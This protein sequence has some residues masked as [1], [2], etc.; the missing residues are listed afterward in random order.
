MKKC[1]I[2]Q[3]SPQKSCFKSFHEL[4]ALRVNEILLISSP[5]DAFVMQED[6]HL[7]ER[8]IHEYQGL[9]LSRPPR[10]SWVSN[11]AEALKDLAAVSYDIVIV[12]PHI[13]DMD[14]YAL[15]GKIKS[16]YPDLPVYYFAYDAGKV[17]K[18]KQCYNRKIIDRTFIWRGNTDLLLALVKNREDSMNVDTDT[19]LADVRV[20]IFVE[21]SPF[22]LSTLLPYLYKE[23][24]MQTQAVMD[25]S[26]NE[27]ERILRMRTRPKILVAENYEQAWALYEKYKE[28]LM[29]VV[30]DVRY[31]KQGK[32]DAEAGIK[33][34]LTINREVPD[35][36]L[37]MLSSEPE[38]R[39]R[40]DAIPAFFLDKNS[41]SL[42]ADIRYFFVHYL[43]FGDFL[44]RMP[45]GRVVARASN[46]RSLA[47]ILHS[48][49]DESIAYHASHNHFSRWLMA[50]FEMQL[51]AGIRPIKVSDFP[52]T[53]HLKEMLT[54]VIRDRLKIK[55]KG[56]I[57]DFVS[58]EYDPDIDFVKIGK[59]SLG[60]KARGLAFI[61][62]MFR[63]NSEFKNLF[64]E[65]NIVLPRIV[66]ITTDGFDAFELE[67]DL[68]KFRNKVHTDGEI[69]DYFKKAGFP[70]W[71]AN[72]LRIFLRHT[73]GPLAVRSS[74][75]LEDAHYRP[76]AGAYATYMLPNNHPKIQVR[77]D[78]LIQA[79]KLVYASL[80]KEAPRVLAR[81][82][83][84]RPE[85]DKMAV[86][87]Q[88]LV[89]C[90]H[91]DFFYPGI[92]GVAQSYNFYP[93]DYMKPEEGVAHMAL[94]LGKI[95]M[96]GGVAIRF[97]PRY[98]QF[99]P[100]FSTVENILKN[101]QRYFYALRMKTENE[102]YITHPDM[103]LEKIN[104]DDAMDHAPVQRFSSTYVPEDGRIR[105]VFTQK[106]YPV[107]TF[108]SIL[109]FKEFPLGKILSQLLEVGRKGMGCPVEMEF[110]VNFNDRKTA[111]FYLLQ[112]RP[113]MVARDKLN[114]EINQNDLN[115]SFC[116]SEQAMG[117]SQETSIHDII[118]VKL[119]D[120]DTTGTVE[121]AEEI[122]QMNEL[123]KHNDR[124]YLLIGP[125]RWGTADPWLGIPVKWSHITGVGTIIET[126]SEKLSAD[127][128]QGSHFF[129]NITSLGINYLGVSQKD[130]NVIDW[131]WLDSQRV[132]KETRYLKYISLKKPAL[133]KINGKDST[134]VIRKPS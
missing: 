54:D 132:E 88:K 90:Q 57:S 78:Q 134:A 55:Q 17:L 76:S 6:G 62:S 59:G 96:D 115:R 4:I 116:Y 84:Y 97:S 2:H 20:V 118:Y 39:E 67:N 48:V 65:A 14:S 103:E 94:G 108:A 119:H 21:D 121:I 43:G 9:N 8:I 15:C 98:P 105:D 40:A 22:Y 29:C 74:A 77:L 113:M 13:S 47:S 129:H 133:I 11:A 58:K 70:Q 102:D 87:I 28:Y 38:N 126:T 36:P 30:S 3:K 101:A 123:L 100:Q 124:K 60:G 127:P 86:I 92:S 23:I 82:S 89:G 61:S 66:V 51:A 71:L 91:G 64:S 10:L 130:N 114:V 53:R 50:R 63:E 42:H 34:L 16:L 33:L 52:S 19:R 99:L 26:L 107:L 110:A 73:Q 32:E 131:H 7:S 46:L 112:I 68:W 80:Y 24:V 69:E 93:V 120:F 25:D 1:P 83:I 81:R 31:E 12:M 56:L 79:I 18:E 72:D 117:R 122:G 104:V 111:E 37:L 41:A 128:S 125:G 95:V 35:L 5:Y 27:K 106:G 44:F 85:D 75:I 49:P 45:D 109:K